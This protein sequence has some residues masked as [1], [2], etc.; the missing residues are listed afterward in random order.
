MA[1]QSTYTPIAT[2]TAP[3]STT[4]SY[5]FSSI[6]QTYTD[7]VL[8]ANTNVVSAGDPTVLVNG[9]T[10][11]NYSDTWFRGDGTSLTTAYYAN[12]RTFWYPEYDSIG[13]T[14]GT[15]NFSY[16]FNFQ[17]YSNTATFKTVIYR[18][19]AAGRSTEF[20]VGLWR[21]TSAITSITV[22]N[23]GGGFF[24]SGSTFTLYGIAAA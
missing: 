22:A 13:G 20:H 17:N 1:A 5:V 23:S 18:S 19:G 9:D 2:Y 11:T 10:G 21:S 4:N 8:A 16:L 12:T 3:N 7:L 14:Q 6:P 15:V 24:V